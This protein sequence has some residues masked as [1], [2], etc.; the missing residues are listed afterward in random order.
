MKNIGT[1]IKAIREREL[2]EGKFTQ[3]QFSELMEIKQEALSRIENGSQVADVK[4]CH[5]LAEKFNISTDWLILGKGN[6][7]YTEETTRLNECED[8]LSKLKFYTEQL[9]RLNR[10]R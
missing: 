1:R 6:I 8:K 3:A 10:E 2:P 5:N 4:L 7:F 9:E